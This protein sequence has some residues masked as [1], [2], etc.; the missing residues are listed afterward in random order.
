[1]PVTTARQRVLAYFKKQHSASAV[2]IGRALN[3]SAANVRHH[4]SVLL[5]D[6]RIV[7]ASEARKEGRGRPIKFYRL[8]ENLLGNNLAL[9][10]DKLL[11]E[12]L[13]KLSPAKRDDALQDLAKALIS[14]IGQTGSKVPVAK[15]L[16]FVVSKL[17]E[18]HYHSHW[19]AGMEGPRVLFAH[20]PY[21]AVVE[22][23]PELCKMDA[24]LLA[25]LLEGDIQQIAKLERGGAPACVFIVK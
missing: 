13:G 3:M 21:A 4:L 24:S 8:S 18:L 1:M 6:G 15:R 14:Q 23:H 10:S 19:E 2:Q 9:L 22:K 20:C 11:D 25:S 17:N 7:M 12:W 16:A 5:S